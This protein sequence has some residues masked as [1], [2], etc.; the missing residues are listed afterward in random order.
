[1]NDF[2]IRFNLK[3]KLDGSLLTIFPPLLAKENGIIKWPIELDKWDIISAE[4]CTEVE[5]PICLGDYKVAFEGDYITVMGRRPKDYLIEFY[6]GMFGIKVLRS[7][8]DNTLEHGAFISQ[9]IK[10]Y[11]NMKYGEG[12]SFGREDILFI[13]LAHLNIGGTINMEDA[14]ILKNN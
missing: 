14:I 6:R 3:S 1:M 4:R 9:Q 2:Q 13:P 10:E 11:H 7:D 8:F 5:I 12:G